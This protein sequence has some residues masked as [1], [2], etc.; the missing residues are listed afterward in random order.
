MSSIPEDGSLCDQALDENDIKMIIGPKP[1]QNSLLPRILCVDDQVF[2]LEFLRCQFELIPSLAD[3][4][5]YAQNGEA[6]LEF[7]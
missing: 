2:N 4:C 3:R 1:N 6:A 5:D 7:I